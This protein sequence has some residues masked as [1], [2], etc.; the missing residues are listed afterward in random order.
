MT[1]RTTCFILRVL[2]YRDLDADV[3]VRPHP[4]PRAGRPPPAAMVDGQELLGRWVIVLGPSDGPANR[5][6]PV[7][8][9]MQRAVRP[10]S[11][12]PPVHGGSSHRRR[13]APLWACYRVLA[14]ALKR[15]AARVPVGV[16]SSSTTQLTCT[17]PVIAAPSFRRIRSTVALGSS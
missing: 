16:T 7:D 11:D 5:D 17:A 13:T 1:R 12:G 2:R 8:T 4:V 3:T 15:S 6:R 9:R 10:G 14:S